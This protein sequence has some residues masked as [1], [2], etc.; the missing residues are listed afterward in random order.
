MVAVSI[1]DKG[2]MVPADKL[3]AMKLTDYGR[4]A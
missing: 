1:E 4:V 3:M 2:Q